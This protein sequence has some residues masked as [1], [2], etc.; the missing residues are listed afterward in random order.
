MPQIAHSNRNGWN[1]L[2]SCILQVSRE[3]CLAV[4]HHRTATTA[5]PLL[6]PC[7]RLPIQIVSDSSCGMDG[8]FQC[9]AELG[10][11]YTA[12]ARRFKTNVRILL[13][14]QS[15]RTTRQNSRFRLNRFAL[16]VNGRALSIL[17]AKGRGGGCVQ[18]N[19]VV[20]YSKTCGGFLER[21]SSLSEDK[22]SWVIPN[23][24]HP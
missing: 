17:T 19:Q 4:R 5:N 22:A 9:A 8:S 10:L 12:C 3:Q 7:V 13:T 24:L 11:K 6:P 21:N 20:K 15:D 16:T 1:S 23:V 18:V 2:R 14:S